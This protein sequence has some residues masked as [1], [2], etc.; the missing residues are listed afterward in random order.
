MDNCN[1]VISGPQSRIMSSGVME[2]QHI[3]GIL[4][5]TGPRVTMVQY[6][7]ERGLTVQWEKGG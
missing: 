6:V 3:R 7:G 2:K 1:C 4:A 5:H